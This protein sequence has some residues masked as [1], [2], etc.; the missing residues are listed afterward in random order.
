MAGIS[1]VPDATQSSGV[2]AALAVVVDGETW[3]QVS[4]LR[5]SRPSDAHYVVRMTE[6]GYVEVGCGDGVHGRRLPTGS[7]NV[8]VVARQGVGEAGNLE[9][10][11]LE[12]PSKPHALVD[13]VQQLLDAS[14][15][16]DGEDTSSLR[17]N[18]PATV[19]T[20]GRAVSISDF[21]L[22]VGRH[23]SVWQARS[24][25]LPTGLA[26]RESV[27][28]VVVPAGGAT[29]TPDL[30]ET[31]QA[32]AEAGALP[33]VSITISDYDPVVVRFEILLRVR[34]SAF[35]PET[36]K[37]DVRAKLEETFSLRQRRLGAPL[38]RGELFGVVEAVT[39]VESS[40][41]QIV[42]D[43]TALLAERRPRVVRGPDGTLRAL[44]P[45]DRQS[46]HL[47]PDD[48]QITLEVEEYAP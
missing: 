7:N 36:V 8:R 25:R 18:G 6:D 13:S 43:E 34:S 30:Q 35:D 41:C 4:P 45:L 40:D 47:D 38:Y 32:F 1:F 16:A 2:R 46:V 10:G 11:S 24:F 3:T 27:E 17:T 29:F 42:F 37:A 26:R 22:L 9:A 20:L 14:G 44:F 12:K 28:V 19:L 31:L 21:G 33:G 48:S 15:G 5:D 23:S 39:G